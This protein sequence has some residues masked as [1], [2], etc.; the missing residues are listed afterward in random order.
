MKFVNFDDVR[1]AKF[2]KYVYVMMKNFN[3]KIYE[4][5][6]DYCILLI[7]CFIGSSPF[8]IFYGMKTRL[9]FYFF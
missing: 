6:N 3:N 4:M 9:L 8:S 5:K 7:S 2:V 1:I